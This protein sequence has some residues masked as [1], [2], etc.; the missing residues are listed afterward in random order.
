LINPK[1]KLTDNS[2]LYARV[3]SGFRPGGS[4]VGVPPG[5][6]APVSFG[7]DKLVSYALGLKSTLLDRRLAIDV[8]AFYIDWKQIQLNTFKGGFSFLSNG[9][10][11]KSQGVEADVTVM[12]VEGLTLSAN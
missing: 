10:E 1:Y 3:A 8:S 4:N 11:A 5:L 9:G 7:P 12:P 6:G 2:N